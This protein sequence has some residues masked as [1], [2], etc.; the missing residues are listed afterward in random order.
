MTKQVRIATVIET[1]SRYLISRL[2]IPKTGEVM[3]YCWGEV[4]ANRGAA[5]RHEGGIVKFAKS[6]V[7]ITEVTKTAKLA[8]ELF[9]QAIKRDKDAGVI[10]ARSGRKHSRYTVIGKRSP[11]FVA[12]AKELGV[13]LDGISYAD[14]RII[15]ELIN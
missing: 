1:G 11:E 8:E 14:V 5:T 10:F 7:E 9:S 2:D 3:V 13:K 15:E 6:E 12:A 4:V